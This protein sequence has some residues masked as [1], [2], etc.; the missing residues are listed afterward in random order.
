VAHIRTLKFHF[1]SHSNTTSHLPLV[2]PNSFFPSDCPPKMMLQ[3]PIHK[4][5]SM[6]FG[7]GAA[8]WSNINFGPTGRHHPLSS[9]LSRAY[10][11]PS[12]FA[13]FKCILE[14]VFYKCVQHRLRFCLDHLKCVKMAAFQFN[15]QS[16]KQRSCREA[17]SG[18]YG[19]WRTQS[20]C[21]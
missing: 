10:T 8:I 4:E 14:V 17:K 18:E 16:E 19:E 3:G 20:C 1:R 7:S 2:L 13:I 11:V 5:P 9:H 15:L 6:I 21:F 12:A